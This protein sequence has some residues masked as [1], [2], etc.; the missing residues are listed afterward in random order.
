MYSRSEGNYAGLIQGNG[1]PQFD[2]VETTVNSD[3]LLPNDRPH[4]FKLSGSYR[5]GFGL[6]LGTTFLWQSGTPLNELGALP[7]TPYTVYLSPRGSMGRTPAT[8][9][10]N[11]RVSYRFRSNGGG[12]KPEVVVDFFHPFSQH[13]ALTLDEQHFFAVDTDGNPTN[14]NPNYLQPTLYQPAFSSRIG[15]AIAF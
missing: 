6:G 1:G 4:A 14:E 5:M 7:G 11:Y 15:L 2:F 3:G 8:W 13:R 12:M 9:D 10:M